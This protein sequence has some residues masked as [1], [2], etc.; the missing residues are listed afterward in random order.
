MGLAEARKSKDVILSF[1]NI[2]LK[3]VM[4]EDCKLMADRIESRINAKGV[5]PREATKRT[6]DLV[7]NI[8]K[9]AKRER[10]IKT[11]PL[12]FLKI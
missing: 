12:S 1:N 8:L 5:P 6:I 3:N 9:R 11:D 4:F 2:A 7:S 10:L